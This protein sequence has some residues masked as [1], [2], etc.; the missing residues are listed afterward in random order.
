MNT[1]PGIVASSFFQSLTTTISETT[2]YRVSAQ[3]L[4][5]S[6]SGYLETINY[7]V[8]AQSLNASTS[9]YLE[10]IY[11]NVSSLSLIAV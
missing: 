4:N 1:I 7:R 10:T 11:Y 8:S 2:N 3:S 6:I 9:G 5:A